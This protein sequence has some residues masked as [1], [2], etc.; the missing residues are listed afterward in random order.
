[1]VDNSSRYGLKTSTDVGSTLRSVEPI[2]EQSAYETSISGRT[3]SPLLMILPLGP[4]HC[5]AI[6]DV[7]G[8]SGS[9]LDLHISV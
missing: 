7:G 3:N 6:V 2:E 5:T 9:L 4:S 8:R 1:M